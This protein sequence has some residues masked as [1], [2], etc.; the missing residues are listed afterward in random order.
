MLH[1]LLSVPMEQNNLKTIIDTFPNVTFH[2]HPNNNNYND[3]TVLSECEVFAT[4][5]ISFDTNILNKMPK[6]R[7]L[8]IFKAGVDNLPLKE[9]QQ[10]KVIVCNVRGIHR[11]PVSEFVFSCILALAQNLFSFRQNQKARK[12]NRNLY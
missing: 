9:L 7:F 12:W 6:L 10:R 8:Q 2:V 11:T 1:V 5:G 3:L 4:F